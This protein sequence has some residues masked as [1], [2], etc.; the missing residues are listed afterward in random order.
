MGELVVLEAEGCE[1]QNRGS[2]GGANVV[3]P[4]IILNFSTCAK[5]NSTQ[6]PTNSKMS[7]IEMDGG[8]ALGVV[9]PTHSQLAERINGGAMDVK[10][11]ALNGAPSV[12][13]ST[14]SSRLYVADSLL[15]PT[16]PDS[17]QTHHRKQ[18]YSLHLRPRKPARQ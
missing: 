8:V 3:H 7:D 11:P 6:L 15:E 14:V 18:A 12:A 1:M 13:D 17:T 4:K 10:S 16:F 9:S 5:V 2:P